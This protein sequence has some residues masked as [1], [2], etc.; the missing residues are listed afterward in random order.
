MLPCDSHGWL[1]QGMLFLVSKQT[2]VSVSKKTQQL[3]HAH[4]ALAMVESPLFLKPHD[5]IL[6]L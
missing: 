6:H 5:A 3:P 1:E 4:L 2:L